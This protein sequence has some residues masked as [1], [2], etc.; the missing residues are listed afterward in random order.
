[1]SIKEN[2]T[3]F[4]YFSISLS[5]RLAKDWESESYRFLVPYQVPASKYF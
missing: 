4:S 2:I 3:I 5:M 1:M